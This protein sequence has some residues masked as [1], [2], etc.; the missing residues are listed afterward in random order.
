MKWHT[1]T[2]LDVSWCLYSQ[3]VSHTDIDTV[4]H[5]YSY[6][7]DMNTPALHP[8]SAEYGAQIRNHNRLYLQE[9]Q[10]DSCDFGLSHPIEYINCTIQL[11]NYELIFKLICSINAPYMPTWLELVYSMDLWHTAILWLSNY[12]LTV[13]FNLSKKQKIKP[14]I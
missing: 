9:M 6:N 1:W 12:L 10:Y 13:S 3:P 5:T 4:T 2:F 8:A 14:Q 7:Q 11:P